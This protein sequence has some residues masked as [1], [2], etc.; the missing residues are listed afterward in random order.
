[1]GR[2]DP[3]LARRDGREREPLPRGDLRE[4][5]SS[6]IREIEAHEATILVAQEHAAAA[7]AHETLD[8]WCAVEAI[9]IEIPHA[10]VL[11]AA[12]EAD[13]AAS[14]IRREGPRDALECLVEQAGA[15][16]AARL[17]IDHGESLRL[18]VHEPFL[19]ERV[20]LVQPRPHVARDRLGHDHGAGARQGDL[21]RRGGPQGRSR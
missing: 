1:V 18:E 5:V 4:L 8:T 16:D 19:G 7:R 21:A 14:P 3:A 13:E 15:Q 2:E 20:E 17:G 9:E 10:D 11:I 6:R 12:C